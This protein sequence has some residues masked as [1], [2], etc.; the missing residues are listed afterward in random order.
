MVA[1][2]EIEGAHGFS[3]GVNTLGSELNF[4]HKSSERTTIKQGY[5]T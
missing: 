5:H 3:I 2:S 4:F 1:L